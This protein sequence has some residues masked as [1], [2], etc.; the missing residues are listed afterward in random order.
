MDSW[1]FLA[2][3]QAGVASWHVPPPPPPPLFQLPVHLGRALAQMHPISKF[4][5][6]HGCFLGRRLHVQRAAPAITVSA[7]LLIP[8]ADAATLFTL[9]ALAA[10]PL[11][12]A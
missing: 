8:C 10:P 5:N 1:I 11:F 3:T 12:P 6:T 7:E 2:A 4:Q 9:S